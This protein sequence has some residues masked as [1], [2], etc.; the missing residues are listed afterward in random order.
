MGPKTPP[1]SS[2][3]SSNNTS[4]SSS[5]SSAQPSNGFDPIGH[6][7]AP[8]VFNAGDVLH[9]QRYRLNR[10]LADGRFTTIWLATDL[11]TQQP[12]VIKVR[13]VSGAEVSGGKLCVCACHTMMPEVK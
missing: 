1:P 4:S 6:G 2:S 8:D 9:N 11:R 12:V 10:K 13:F 7:M 5:S 3:S